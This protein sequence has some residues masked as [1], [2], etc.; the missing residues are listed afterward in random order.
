[1]KISHELRESRVSVREA[2]VAFFLF[3][4]REGM[5]VWW[6][7]VHCGGGGVKKRE[8]PSSHSFIGID[9]EKGE[10]SSIRTSTTHQS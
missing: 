5:K 8:K 6:V 2:D 7:R 3:F 1:M 10:R 4:L 9:D